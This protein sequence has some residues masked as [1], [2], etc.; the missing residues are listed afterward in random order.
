MP[1]MVECADAAVP[2]IKMEVISNAN[3]TS[4]SKHFFFLRKKK[5]KQLDNRYTDDR[6]N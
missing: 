2:H 4:K 3:N 6:K 5:G 1:D